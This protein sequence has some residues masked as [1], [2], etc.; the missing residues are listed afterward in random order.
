M[1]LYFGPAHSTSVAS[2][3]A[4]GVA[5]LRLQPYGLS[6]A[7]PPGSLPAM[8]PPDDSPRLYGD[9]EV[10][11]ILKRATELQDTAPEPSGTGLSLKEL[12]EIA[13]EAG[14]DPA[15]LRRAAAEVE[16]GPLASG[17]STVFLGTSPTIS[18]E[19][20]IQGEI[21]EDVFEILLPEIQL[22]DTGQGIP[23]LFGRTLTWR[24]NTASNTR[25]LQLTVS[26][27]DGETQIRIEE[28]LHG[29]AGGLFGGLV[30][31][32]GAGIG[33][34]VGVGVGVDVL[35]SVLF[36]VAF[37]LG[38][39]GGCY[40]LA[41]SIFG[42]TVRRRQRALHGLM[43]RLT[44]IVEREVSRKVVEGGQAPQALPPGDAPA[45]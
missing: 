33:V 18:L 3:R 27:R 43:E 39:I 7:D 36:S 45:S 41:R 5:Q 21:T 13:L 34:G 23:S 8:S 26:S 31:G 44:E 35:G 42:A 14:I 6:H 25:S 12:E 4:E 17:F 10:G 22:L 29:F 15:H 9:R 16:A 20:V 28:Q 30:G 37:P 24:S 2:D 1:R 19:R 40:L 11:L 32:G 38:V